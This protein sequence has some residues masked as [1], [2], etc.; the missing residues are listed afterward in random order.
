MIKS[1]I[2]TVLMLFVL[3]LCETNMFSQRKETLDSN[4]QY[5]I[6]EYTINDYLSNKHFLPAISTKLNHS[7]IFIGISKSILNDTAIFEVTNSYFDVEKVLGD[8]MNFFNNIDLNSL[9]TQFETKITGYDCYNISDQ[10]NKNDF[11]I[12]IQLSDI[13]HKENKYFVIVYGVSKFSKEFHP[14][15]NVLYEFEE[16]EK[17][18]FLILNACYKDIGVNSATSLERF[19]SFG[20]LDIHHYPCK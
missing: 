8:N 13:Y 15:E 11:S 7:E 12:F 6:F 9:I 20:Y 4:R 14:N 19:G 10:W 3:I 16:C 5:F 17:N 2:K 1:I 18:G